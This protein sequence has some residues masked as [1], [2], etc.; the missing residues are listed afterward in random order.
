MGL[1][2]F[3]TFLEERSSRRSSFETTTCSV[4]SREVEREVT[5]YAGRTI[6]GT[7]WPPTDEERRACCPVHGRSPYNTRSLEVK[8]KKELHEQATGSASQEVGDADE[9]ASSSASLD[10]EHR[11]QPEPCRSPR[12][13]G[14]RR[15]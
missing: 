14:D 13:E 9:R 8:R 2:R 10:R 11:L 5:A 15:K 6:P 1:R 12:V 3:L 4:C 7:W